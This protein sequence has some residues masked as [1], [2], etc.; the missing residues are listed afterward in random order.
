MIVL[1]GCSTDG[2]RQTGTATE[3]KCDSSF[4]ATECNKNKNAFLDVVSGL[5]QGDLYFQN[6]VW[7]HSIRVLCDVALI[8][9]VRPSARYFIPN[10]Q[11]LIIIVSFLIIEFNPDRSGNVKMQV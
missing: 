4:V 8:R 6:A 10:P 2:M 3:K 7:L 11:L 5:S 9:E 1:M